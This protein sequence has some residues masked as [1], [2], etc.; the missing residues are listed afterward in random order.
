MLTMQQRNMG[1]LLSLP[2]DRLLHMFR[3]TA[4][5]PSTAEPLGGWEA[6]DC[7]LRGHFAGG[8]L[9]SAC[10]LMYASTGD[11]RF[12]DKGNMLVAELAKCQQPDGYL[13]AYPTSFYDRLRNHEKVWAPFYT[14]HKIMAGHLDM[15]THCGNGQA[16]HTAERMADWANNW[17][18][19]I[20]ASNFQTI[21]KV[22]YGGMQEVLFNLYAV[23]GNKEYSRLAEQFS[24]QS[25]FDPLAAN[26]DDLPGIHANTHIPQ[27][28]GA[29]RGYEVEGDKRY[30]TIAANFWNDVVAEHSYATGGT[31]NGE[32]WHARGT[33][34]ENLGPDAQEC[35]CAYNMMKLSRHLLSWT[36]DARIADQYERMLWNVRW[37][38]QDEAG[39]LMYYVSL[40]PGLHRTFGTEFDSFWCCTG[41]GSEEY[42]KANDSIYS[43]TPN[44][45]YV[46]QF[47]GS[48]LNWKEK[49]L[50]LTQETDFP[51]EERTR[52]AF[53]LKH[54]LHTTLMIR[55]PYWAQGVQ[56][57]IN[58]KPHRIQAEPGTYAAID[59][60]WHDGDAVTIVL[61]MHLHT[62]ALPGTP[63]IQAAM[64][65]PLVLAA[66]MGEATVPPD[67]LYGPSGPRDAKQ[68]HLAMPMVKPP[69][70]A[71]TGWLRRLPGPGIAFETVGLEQ[72]LTLRPLAELYNHRYSVY[73]RVEKQT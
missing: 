55:V 40:D 2:N 9:L 7:E 46:N 41:T 70:D 58:G 71:P 16:L 29:A 22:E 19:P 48:T 68:D 43:H 61:P 21:L 62:A 6:A 73:L 53:A 44:A 45:L 13:S 34:A 60:K 65:G 30:R 56:V 39:M 12:R 49:G 11:E 63:Q 15:Y 20:S 33:L 3:V 10:A 23:T 18:Q 4:G 69:A 24:H 27:V 64:Y 67:R 54:S 36:A 25:F 57:T 32:Y 8:H 51:Y 52:L 47:I 37:G 38:T 1:F 14:Y 66:V 50:T 28:I 26:Q 42:S 31:S 35:C 72:P 59:R 17:V 5:L